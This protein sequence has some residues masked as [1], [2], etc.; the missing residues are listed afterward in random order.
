M[1]NSSQGNQVLIVESFLLW[2]QKLAPLLAVAWTLT[3]EMYF[4]LVFT[5]M[6]WGARSHLPRYL[7]FW[8]IAVMVGNLVLPSA[9]FPLIKIIFHPLTLEFI[10]GCIVAH[11]VFRG[12]TGYGRLY[13]Y[14][15]GILLLFSTAGCYAYFGSVLPGGWYRVLFFGVPCSLMVYGAVASEFKGG[16]SFPPWLNAI[17]D[18]SYSIYLSHVLVLSFLGRVW[19]QFGQEGLYDNYLVFALMILLVMV[20]GYLSFRYIE[21][22]IIRSFRKYR[23]KI[24]MGM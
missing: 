17:G 7:F 10:A 3:H 18:A 4:Y 14:G 5:L 24:F 23:A 11:I 6:L 20:Y 22:P 8:T 15:G 2:P 9:T 12:H 21:K 19:Y 16:L 13:F 1:V